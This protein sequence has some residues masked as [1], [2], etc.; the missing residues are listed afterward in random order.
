MIDVVNANLAIVAFFPSIGKLVAYAVCKCLSFGV[1]GRGKEEK[2]WSI[3][4][5]NNFFPFKW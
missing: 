4:T 2:V 3:F 5:S 1:A